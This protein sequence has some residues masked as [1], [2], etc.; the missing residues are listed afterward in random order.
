MNM[1]GVT[2]MEQ[3]QK[4]TFIHSISFKI[5][6]LVIAIA[7]FTLIGSV[8]SAYNEAKNILEES[9]ENYILSLA[10]QG[11]QTITN[12]PEEL[13]NS[14]EYAAVMQGIEMKG[15]DSAYAYLVSAD[16]TMLYHPTAEKIGQSVENSVIKGVVAEIEAG[17][18]PQNEVVEYDYK[19]EIKYAGYALTGDNSIVVVTADK[20]DIT[21]P[22]SRMIN[23]M[24]GCALGTL[25]IS[26]IAGY[27]VSKFICKPI[28]QMTEIVEKTARLDFTSTENGS[29]LRK[30]HDETGLM[31]REVH[32]MR[33][34]LRDIVTNINETSGQITV[35]VDGLKQ[36]T[37]LINTMCTD[38]SAT[39]EQLAAGMEEAAATTINVNENVQD[40]KQNA[41]DIE[42]MAQQGA[43]QSDEVMQRAKNLGN[44]T[45]QAS[46]RTMQMY[47]NVKDKSEKAIEGSKAVDKI[48]ELTGTIMEISSQ[49]G[50]LALN[51]SIEAARAGEAGK[52]FAVVATEIGSLADQTTRAI[53]D[54]GTIVKEVN[55]AVANMT[56]CMKETTEFL[57]Q[58]VL[59]DYKEFK[60]VSVQY[61][62]DADAYGNDMNQVRDAVNQLAGLAVTSA[63]ALDGIKDTVN[64]SATGVTDIAQKTSDMVSKAVEA[65]DMVTEC[66]S[67]ADNLKAIV[68]RFKLH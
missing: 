13:I 56:E 23:Y 36:V 65:N 26:V 68:A 57:E 7:I 4:V 6:L 61:Q 35:N 11:A 48:N 19:G 59:A 14:D 2:I 12:I 42:Q 53:E 45:E 44:K 67:C 41:E 31:A 21:D 24:L 64:E 37:D 38:N 46:N 62:E 10:E 49:T 16:G 51:A 55:E 66:Y 27:M 47:Q 9:N 40:M 39:T 8:I 18:T 30:R 17:K 50:L 15:I 60:E 32:L 1:K 43:K 5:V 52:G 20:S 25:I 29:S 3:T 54:I 28:Q 34:N 22:L 58:S 33:G 63:G